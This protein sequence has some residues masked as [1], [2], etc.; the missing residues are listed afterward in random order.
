[1]TVGS[2]MLNFDLHPC[3]PVYAYLYAIPVPNMI[4]IYVYYAQRVTSYSQPVSNATIES[5][6][7]VNA[8]DQRRMPSLEMFSLRQFSDEFTQA[9]RNAF[10]VVPLEKAR[11]VRRDILRQDGPMLLGG[12]LDDLVRKEPLQLR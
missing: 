8:T 4:V 6:F 12:A 7:V 1:M 5:L 3:A 10:Y 9:H 2:G 11:F